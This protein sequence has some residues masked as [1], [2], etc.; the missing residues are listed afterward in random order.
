MA[1]KKK[2][3]NIQK[4]REMD[5]ETLENTMRIR[6]DRERIEDS[7]SLD[8]SFLEGRAHKRV[9]NNKT[10]K[11]KILIEKKPT[12]SFPFFK[13]IKILLLI[14]L[15]VGVVVLKNNFDNKKEKVV[16]YDVPKEELPVIDNN[17]LFV[18]DYHTNNFN[19]EEFDL[20]YHYVKVGD[21]NFTISKVLD[22]MN[23]SIY[24]YNPSIVFLELG[25][26]DILDERDTDDI[27]ND[28][29]KVIK[30]ILDN[31]PYAKVYVES[32]Y[33]INKDVED[34]D[35]DYEDIEESTLVEFNKR[36]KELCETLKVSYLDIYSELSDDNH[37]IEKYTD[38]GVTLN[39]LGYERVFKIIRNV[40]DE[41]K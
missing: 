15:L 27:V 23:E 18:G 38:D 8:T 19:F 25:I 33:P 37:L 41:E 2:T 6:I 35:S 17:Y 26:N 21:E 5:R 10:A 34:F 29:E 30:G 1:K 3:D 9:Q 13:I 28:M 12:I 31:R 36:I 24:R 16:D 40:V 11:E 14:I 22:S 20:D 4:K 39:T 7:E 32:I